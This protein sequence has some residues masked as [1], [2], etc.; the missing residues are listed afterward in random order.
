MP[1]LLTQATH[2]AVNGGFFELFVQLFHVWCRAIAL[3]LTDHLHERYSWREDVTL[4]L[5]LPDV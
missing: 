4:E 3:V 2:E 5:A 1:L